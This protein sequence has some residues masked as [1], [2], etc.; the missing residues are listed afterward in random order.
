M[1]HIIEKIVD[2]VGYDFALLD[3]QL[4]LVVSV[5]VQIVIQYLHLYDDQERLDV[6][7]Y[8]KIQYSLKDSLQDNWYLQKHHLP[9][10]LL[11]LLFLHAFDFLAQVRY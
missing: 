8:S 5:F 9:K 1:T 10:Q 11:S 2:L 3:L 4:A 7:K 6:E